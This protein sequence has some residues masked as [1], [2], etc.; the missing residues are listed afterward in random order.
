[1][2]TMKESQ[3]PTIRNGIVIPV[4]TPN[5]AVTQVTQELHKIKQS[6]EKIKQ[7]LHEEMIEK[8]PDAQS[9]DV[10][11]AYVDTLGKIAT[12]LKEITKDLSLREKNIEQLKKASLPSSI[13]PIIQEL[14]QRTT[15]STNTDD[16]CNIINDILVTNVY[17]QPTTIE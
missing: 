8:T 12:A 2:D 9:T 10:V 3:E 11:D 17:I 4:E 16:C 15:T 14:L 6:C 7:M 5:A 13:M 1:M